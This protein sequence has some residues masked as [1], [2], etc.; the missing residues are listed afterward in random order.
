MRAVEQAEAESAA[1]KKKEGVEFGNMGAELEKKKEEKFTYA[2]LIDTKFDVWMNLQEFYGI[3]SEFPSEYLFYQKDTNNNLVFLSDGLTHSLMPCKRKYKLKVVNIGVKMFSKNRDD[4]S[5][6]NYRL[7]QEGLEI[8]M[9]LM[10]DRRKVKVTKELFLTFLDKSIMTYEDIKQH[11]C[12][13]QFEGREH[14]SAVMIYDSE[15]YATV[16]IGVNNV[17]LMVNKE[18]IKSFRFLIK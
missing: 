16:W 6:A 15:V 13:E 17:S 14:G 9:P 12:I 2:K 8:L 3:S 10:D 4:K 11:E 7:L 18:E 1:R 5:P